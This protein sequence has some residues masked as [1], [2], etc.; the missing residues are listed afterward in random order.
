MKFELEIDDQ[1]LK[2]MILQRL[3]DKVLS[4]AWDTD[5]DETSGMNSSQISSFKQKKRQ[6][7]LDKINWTQVADKLGETVVQKMFLRLMDK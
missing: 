2:Q 1:E 7:F 6:A 4:Y 3:A 5:W